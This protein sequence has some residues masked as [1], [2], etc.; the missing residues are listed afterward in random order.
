MVDNAIQNCTKAQGFG[1]FGLM[2]C[3]LMEAHQIQLTQHLLGQVGHMGSARKGNIL[4]ET[5][6]PATLYPEPKN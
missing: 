4:K 3:I 2:L 1:Q 6:C 5:F